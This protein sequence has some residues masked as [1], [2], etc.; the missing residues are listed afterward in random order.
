MSSSDTPTKPKPNP[1]TAAKYHEA[2]EKV[3]SLKKKVVDLRSQSEADKAKGG[4]GFG[5]KITELKKEMV[6]WVNK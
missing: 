6:E 3:E 4:K 1:D 5:E 2:A